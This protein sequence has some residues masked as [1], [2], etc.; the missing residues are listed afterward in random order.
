MGTWQ[1]AWVSWSAGALLIAYM[2]DS[3]V[4]LWMF[5]F[6]RYTNDEP[7]KHINQIRERKTWTRE[8]NQLALHCY[9][10]S[11]PTL[12]GYRAIMMEIMTIMCKFPDNKPM[13]HGPSYDN[14]NEKLVFWRWNTRNTPE[15]K[16]WTSIRHTMCWQ[17]RTF[18]PK[19]P[20]NFGK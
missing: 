10:W 5:F 19:W 4:V 20:T 8:D 17:T 15:N 12:R 14:N 16:W 6:F 18:S 7:R 2:G 11:N 13:T 1:Q 9:F 3:V